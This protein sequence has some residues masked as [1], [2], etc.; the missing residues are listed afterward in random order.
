MA[1][2]WCYNFGVLSWSIPTRKALR[3]LPFYLLIPWSLWFLYTLLIDPLWL[4][5]LNQQRALFKIM[6]FI[7][8]ARTVIRFAVFAFMRNRSVSVLRVR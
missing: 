7:W 4:D 5:N 3:T 6:L 8:A 1:W 2:P